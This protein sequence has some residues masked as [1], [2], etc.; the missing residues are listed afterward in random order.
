VCSV[1]SSIAERSTLNSQL[2]RRRGKGEWLSRQERLPYTQEVTGSNPVSPTRKTPKNPIVARVCRPSEQAEGPA[3]KSFPKVR[4][5]PEQGRR[6]W[7]AHSAPSRLSHL[8]EFLACEQTHKAPATVRNHSRALR[9]LE[10]WLVCLNGKTEADVER[11]DLAGFLTAQKERL[12]ADDVNN[13]TAALR[14]YFAWLQEEGLRSDNPAQG[15][16]FL[17]RPPKPV[18]PLTREECTRLLRYAEKAGRVHP[19]HGRRERFGVLRSAVLVLFLMDTGL[20]LGEALSLRVNDVD[21]E[22]GK[23]IVRAPKTNSLRM[24]PVSLPLRRWLRRFLARRSRI[25]GSASL[26][27]KGDYLFCAEHGGRLTVREAGRSLKAL[28]QRAG[29]P[30]LHAHLL[31]HTWAVHSLQNGAPLPVIMRAGGWRKL[32][33]VNRYTQ[34]TDAMVKEAMEKASPLAALAR[35]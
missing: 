20:R 16:R 6:V 11:L 19:E 15:L 4:V 28:G 1:E 33:T 31:R 3:A 2:R 8:S 22:E 10:A 30:R 5:Y 21:T 7:P 12:T 27:I 23:V 9:T 32:E 25:H 24:V 29:I 18:E 14:V 17:R 26:T 35:R 34:F 13:F